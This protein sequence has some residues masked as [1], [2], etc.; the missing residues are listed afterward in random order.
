MKSPHFPLVLILTILSNLA[1]AQFCTTDNRFTEEEYFTDN[2]IFSRLN[3]PYGTAADWLGNPTAL[4][5]DVYFPRLGV[6]PLPKR[7]FVMMIHGGGFKGG[8]K[9]AMTN[10]CIEFAK[11]GF[12]AATIS[13]RLGW[14]QSDP[15]D[16]VLASYRAHQDANAALRFVV[17]NANRV[18]IDTNWLFIGGS[19]AG[20]ITS[21]NAIYLSQLEW[22]AEIPGITALLGP[23]NTSGNN[24]TNTFE[25]QGVF[26]NWGMTLDNAIN[27]ADMVPSVA[28]HGVLDGVTPIGTGAIF[29][30]GPVFSGS[31]SIH[32]YLLANGVCSELTV[33]SLGGHG[34]YRGNAGEDF[35]VSRASCFF[36]SVFCDNCVSNYFVDSVAANCA[37]PLSIVGSIDA[38]GK[39]ASALE[40]FPNPVDELL[41][42]QGDLE[43]YQLEL[44]NTTGRVIRQVDSGQVATTIN[45]A[46]L[47]PGIYFL[48]ALN[49]LDQSVELRKILI[50]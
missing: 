22:E 17:N 6:D 40:V 10:Y 50:Q 19:S 33:D 24:L 32:D 2:Q 35:R 46:D 1:L 4:R 11:R 13:Y 29:P 48:R 18:R 20:S 38:L 27:P 25:L 43:N 21:L 45:V 44:I 41:N 12:V 15:N 28:F 34:I 30:G 5:M 39:K 31:G 36:K 14:D 26:N 9:E 16:Q 7:P 47:A 37:P 23:L 3:I 49:T 8:T 42:I